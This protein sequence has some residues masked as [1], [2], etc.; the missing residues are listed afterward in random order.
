MPAKTEA[1]PFARVVCRKCRTETAALFANKR[2]YLYARCPKCFADQA[3]GAA[4]QEYFWTH[5][6]LLPGIDPGD[7]R[8]PPNLPEYLGDIGQP[9]PEPPEPAPLPVVPVPEPSHQVKAQA[10]PAP[11]P[12]EESAKPAPAAAKQEQGTD[13][14]P[15]TPPEKGAKKG[16]GMVGIVLLVAG[17]AGAIIT[18]SAMGAPKQ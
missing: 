18:G 6:R 16:G 3:N 8:R 13:K 10:S 9:A 11:V 7:V 12:A 4:A 1:T 17:V 15:D 5:A 2:D 14:K